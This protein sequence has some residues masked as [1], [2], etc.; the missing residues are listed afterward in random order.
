[1]YEADTTDD[2]LNASKESLSGLGLI[3][4][5]VYRALGKRRARTSKTKTQIKDQLELRAVSEKAL[6]GEALDTQ[7]TLVRALPV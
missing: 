1:M 3:S 2:D 4:V 6:K 5:K 7:T